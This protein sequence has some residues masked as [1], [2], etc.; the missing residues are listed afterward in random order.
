MISDDRT[1]DQSPEYLCCNDFF[2]QG[3][4]F[5]NLSTSTNFVRKKRWFCGRGNLNYDMTI[6]EQR[7]CSAQRT[8]ILENLVS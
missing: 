6:Q 2:G 5:V 7:T 1:A 3:S 4:S 8:V